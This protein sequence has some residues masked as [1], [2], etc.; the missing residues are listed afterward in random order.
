[1]SAVNIATEDPANPEIVALLETHLALMHS[2]SPS[3][4]VHALDVERLRVPEVTFWTA[5]EGTAL[6]GCGA[7]REIEAG[8][9]EIKSMHVFQASRGRGIARRMV[10]HILDEARS[11]GYER[12]S[13]E[14]GST[15]HFKPA[16]TLYSTFG[17]SECG[18]FLG[19]EPDEH[20]VFMTRLL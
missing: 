18:P 15:E 9:G 17:F 7:L 11:R 12:L 20:S 19:Y 14:T 2:I 16:R 8:H 1:M 3:E 10:E 13:L 4:S 6:A 5:R